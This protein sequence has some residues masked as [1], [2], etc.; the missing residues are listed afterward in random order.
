MIINL[1][2]IYPNFYKRSALP[3][4]SSSNT[5]VG[6][7]SLVLSNTPLVVGSSD[8]TIPAST[9]DLDVSTN[10]DSAYTSYATAANRVGKDIYVYATTNGIILSPNTTVPTGYTTLTSRKIAGFHCLCLAVGT[11]SGHSLTGFLA[12]DIL[13]ASIWDL[14]WKPACSPEGMVYSAAA[15]V[16]VDIY[17]QSGTGA[18]TRSAFAVTTT[19]TRAYWDHGD[20]LAAVGKRM[21][22][23]AEFQQIA[24]G[25]NEQTNIAG[26]VDP[27]TTGGHVDTAGRR[28]IS[29]IGCEDCTGAWWQ[30]VDGG[31]VYRNHDSVYNGAWSNKSTNGRGQQYTQGADGAVGILAGGGWN[32]GSRCGSRS[33]SSYS[34]RSDVFSAFSSRGCARSQ[35]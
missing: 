22:T 26:S 23:D 28:M 8:L 7:R 31:F 21:L 33:R 13:P 14:Q 30:W 16:W 10:W 27:V 35:A 18:T 24:L 5:A 20:D 15:G 19:S 32:A 17:L 3:S 12:G 11:I 2:D 4:I 29:H 6:R 1:R 25:G 9:L 34:T